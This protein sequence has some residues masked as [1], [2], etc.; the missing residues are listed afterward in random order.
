MLNLSNDNFESE[1]IDSNQL[2]LVDFKAEWCGP[3]KA[4]SPLLDQLQTKYPDV[5]IAKL[6]VDSDRDV[7]VMYGVK[8]L[9]TFILFKNG[10]IVEKI[11]GSTTTMVLSSKIDQH[12]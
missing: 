12:K 2:V 4:M 5:K 11:I 6:D 3:C 7:A 8:S 1:V 10:N 9:P